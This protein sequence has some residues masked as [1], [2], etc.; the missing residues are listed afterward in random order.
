[1]V[2]MKGGRH[3]LKLLS[4]FWGEKN[5]PLYSEKKRAEVA[6]K[7][8]GFERSH[9]GSGKFENFWIPTGWLRW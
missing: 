2:T 8:V 7:K 9:K 5:S 1:M 6:S 4:D 3:A